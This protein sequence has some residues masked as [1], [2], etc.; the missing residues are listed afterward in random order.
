MVHIMTTRCDDSSRNT[1]WMFLI[2]SFRSC[3]CAGGSVVRILFKAISRLN[4]LNNTSLA[5]WRGSLN[6]AIQN[7]VSVQSRERERARDMGPRENHAAS[8]LCEGLRKMRESARE[9]RVK[10]YSS[11]NGNLMI[12][13]NKINMKRLAG[14]L[15][16][17]LS[18]SL[19]LSFSCALC[20]FLS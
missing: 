9:L 1:R 13:M 7:G 11:I 15:S 4:S 20:L 3:T 2:M 10:S 6:K 12:V 16:F 19:S 8:L 14:P 5:R 18:E 17:A